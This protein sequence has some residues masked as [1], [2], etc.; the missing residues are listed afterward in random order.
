[1]ETKL[2]LEELTKVYLDFSNYIDSLDEK[3]F[4]FTNSSTWTAGQQLDHIVKSVAPINTFMKLPDFSKKLMFGKNKG[5]SRTSDEVINDY[6]D[7]LE[8]GGKAPSAYVPKSIPFSQKADLISKLNYI[9]KKIVSSIEKLNEKDIDTFRAPH[10]LI[11]KLTVRE[12]VYFSIY[13]VGHHQKSI[14]KLLK[15]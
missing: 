8:K 5:N 6:L 9:I 11:G 1:M 10:P 2:M 14:Q 15:K 7:K 3:E 13:H 4:S 12:L